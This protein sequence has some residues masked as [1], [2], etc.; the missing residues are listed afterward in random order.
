MSFKTSTGRVS[1]GSV[2]RN[3]YSAN[4]KISFD[5][6]MVD[7]RGIWNAADLVTIGKCIFCSAENYSEVALRSDGLAIQE[8][9]SCGLAFIDPR[10]SPSQLAAYYSDGYFCG[11]RDFFH[12]KN[13]CLARDQSVSAGEVT[14]YREIV[15]NFDLQGKTVLDVGC[16]SGALLC[17]LREHKTKEVIGIDSAEYPVSFGIE[18]YGLDLRRATLEQAQ[19]PSASFDLV[20]LIDLI[21][22]V[23][24]LHNF[25]REVRRVLK[26]AGNIF[27]ITPNYLAYSFARNR[28]TCLYKDFEHLQYFGEQSLR[29]V[30][31]QI[32]WSLMK[33]WTDSAPFRTYEYPRL[34]KH[35]VHRLLHPGVSV[36]NGIA[37]F[38]YK[39]AAANQPLL[40][41]NLNAIIR[42]QESKSF[43]P[44]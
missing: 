13:Y 33:C 25:L 42:L 31:G 19:L 10:P 9:A 44:S 43:L 29:E 27:I 6:R 20:T 24:D 32:G 35:G 18:H 1:T 34:Y 26:P 38:R 2:L 7:R 16:A 11:E 37:Q 4:G 36:R 15:A 23:E 3:G 40:G 17:L 14:G 22:H 41:V 39:R 30:C 12:G 5:P 8:C 21:E 28:W